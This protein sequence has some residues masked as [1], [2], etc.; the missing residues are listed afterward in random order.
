MRG[1][2][3]SVLVCAAAGT[4]AAGAGSAARDNARKVLR[5]AK[6]SSCHD[7]GVS[8]GNP[9]ALAVYDLREEDWSARMSDAR[10]PKLLGRLRSAPA[11]DRAAVRRFIDVELRARVA[12]KRPPSGARQGTPESP[13]ESGPIP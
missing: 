4:A 8:T 3:I 7:S 5:S 13:R 6:C 9:Q 1:M 12:R 10:L 11:A 2:V